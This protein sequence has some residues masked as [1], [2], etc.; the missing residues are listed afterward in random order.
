MIVPPEC[1]QA[2]GRLRFNML[3]DGMVDKNTGAISS[4]LLVHVFS[5]ELSDCCPGSKVAASDEMEP[6][7]W[8]WDEIPLENMWLDDKYWLPQLLQGQD[9]VGDFVFKN[10]ETLVKHNVIPLKMGTYPEDPEGHEAAAALPA[11]TGGDV[12]DVEK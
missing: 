12:Q 7:W 3:S 9:V 8:G 10:Q 6:Q 4:I 1:M 11:E 5:A 2:R